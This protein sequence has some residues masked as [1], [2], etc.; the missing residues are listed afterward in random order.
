MGVIQT[1]MVEADALMNGAEQVER[2]MLSGSTQQDVRKMCTVLGI[3][4]AAYRLY[5]TIDFLT[6]VEP[7]PSDDEYVPF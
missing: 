6:N 3:R 4:L 2:S 1:L 7:E 5:D